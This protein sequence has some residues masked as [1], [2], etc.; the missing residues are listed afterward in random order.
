MTIVDYEIRDL[1]TRVRPPLITNFVESSLKNC[2]YNMRAAKAFRP[3]TGEPLVLQPPVTRWDIKPS[4]TLVI[5]TRESVNMPGYLYASYCQLNRLAEKGLMLINVSIVEPGYRGPLSC[6]LV[7]FSRHVVHLY[8]DTEVAKICFHRLSHCPQDLS[9]TE[10]KEADYERN[11]SSA[12]ESYPVSFMDI[13]GAEERIEKEVT[14]R[15]TAGVNKSIAIAVVFIAVL[16]FF[17]TVEPLVSKFIWERRGLPPKSAREE[18]MELSHDLETKKN[19][20]E[21]ALSEAKAQTTLNEL[22]KRVA[23]QARQIAEL[24][25]RAKSR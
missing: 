3:Q 8:P 15:V 24:Q 9:P 16:V 10:I 11:L 12:A 21:K 5:M 19:E 25:Q 20:A 1:A 18:I 17:S 2:R 13:G 4:E 7:N 22:E 14:E 23:D 6:F